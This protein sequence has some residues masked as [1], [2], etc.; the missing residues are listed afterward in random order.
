[1]RNTLKI[2]WNGLVNAYDAAFAIILS[3]IYFVVLSIPIVT[4][5]LTF[6]G[7]F[8]TNFQIASGES[9]DWKTFFV[10]IKLYWWAGIRWTVV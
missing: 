8:Y 2:F 3:N 10:G 9:V 7:L 4:L 6:A 5:P 1:M